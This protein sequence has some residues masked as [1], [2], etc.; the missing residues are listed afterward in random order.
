[1]K[2]ILRL[3]FICFLLITVS[4]SASAQF[5]KKDSIRPSDCPYKI[6][7]KLDIPITAIGLVT[8][9]L[10]LKVLRAKK[11]LDTAD[12]IHLTPD[13]VHWIDRSAAKV[14]PEWAPG[15][16]LASDIALTTCF[17][18]P[19]I[20]YLDKEIRKDAFRIAL[21]H[22]E[23]QA[24]MGNLY[25]LTMMVTKRK[26]PYVYN[27]DESMER[28]LRRGNTNS[29]Y[30]GHVA[31]AASC[32]FY[33]AKVYADYHPF[34]KNKGLL[35]IPALVPPAI[36]GYLRYR[37]G[38]HFLTD[39]IAGTAVGGF[40]GILIPQIHKIRKKEN[41]SL[42]PWFWRDSRGLSLAYKF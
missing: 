26:R 13:D 2:V 5:W 38:Q 23:T 41:V 30:G 9:T 18:L 6:K 15:A 32:S 16:N 8:N 33:I 27:V 37:G 25:F 34:M 12:V 1:M 17:V 35:Y 4:P 14:N 36:V 24:I 42:S 11:R 31:S 10:G 3:S 29:F 22:V 40:V 19:G 28:R 7:P 39:M 21:M 20:L